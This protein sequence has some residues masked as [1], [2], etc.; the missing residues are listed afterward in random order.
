VRTGR[1]FGHAKMRLASY[2]VT[3]RDGGVYVVA[4]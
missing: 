3:V 1:H 2:P 4:K